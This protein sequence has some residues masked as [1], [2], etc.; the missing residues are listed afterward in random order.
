MAQE[1]ETSAP[2][3]QS[4]AERGQPG[5]D[6][7]LDR[8]P[9]PAFPPGTRRAPS[10]RPV[11]PPQEP[12]ANQEPE[13]D[14]GGFP[15]GALISPDEPVRRIGDGLPRDALISPDDPIAPSAPY[16]G[17]TGESAYE[18]EVTGIGAARE[19]LLPL[20]QEIRDAGRVAEMLEAVARHLRE[21]GPGSLLSTSG[22]SRLESTVRGLIAGYL[23]D[24]EN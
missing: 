21:D 2:S 12:G 15:E 13:S 17:K 20:G 16:S 4:T 9:P 24:D 11:R 14:S 7:E 5:P 18:V 22:T 1:F 19:A 8:L 3:R 10:A 23:L 6:R